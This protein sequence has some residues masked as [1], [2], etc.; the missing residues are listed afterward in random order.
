MKKRTRYRGRSLMGGK[1]YRICVR[2]YGA[3]VRA[4]EARAATLRAMRRIGRILT[5]A[6][7]TFD[8][9]A[10]R[11]LYVIGFGKAS[12]AMA[13][14]AEATLYGPITAGIV[15][16]K[17]DHA[18]P[19]QI[20]AVR[21]ASHPTPDEAGIAATTE[22]LALCDA[23][24]PDDLV[25]C[26]V[27]GGGSA[28]FECPVEGLTLED[29]RETTRVLL[30]AGAP[31]TALN[32]VRKHLSAVKG[33]QLAR[34]VAPAA[35][36]TLIL[37]DVIGDPLNVIASGPTVPDNTTFAQALAVLDTYGVRAEVPGAVYRHLRDGAR[38]L[39]PDTPFAGKPFFARTHTAIIANAQRALDA[40]ARAATAMG[41]PTL[42]LSGGM[43]G[44]ARV[45]AR[46]FVSMAWQA[47]H[48]GQPVPGPVCL[49]AAGETTVTVTGSGVGGRNTEFA[50]AAALALD[51]TEGIVIGALATD[52]GDGPTDAGG[53]VV[54]SH[55]VARAR[56]RGMDPAEYLR[57]NDAYTFFTHVGGLARPGPTNTNV[58]DLMVA[59]I[60]ESE[61]R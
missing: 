3:T 19:T 30:V 41:Y 32:V 43:E 57:N 26:L 39:F 27:S 7:Q 15:V 56:A 55:T 45:T 40:V 1:G 36:V 16:T 12:S 17:Y 23:A 61:T 58:N 46:L 21:E 42:V 37:S 51:G 48:Y 4:V 50:L 13:Q 47:R 44:E 14:A 34:R 5:V 10:V 52:G 31:I 11:N 35:L 28:L 29:V 2:L 9:D 6:G 20:V 8:F 25:L 18:L 38:G 33:G 60:E 54:H 49:L 59:L 22:I 53:A 24:G